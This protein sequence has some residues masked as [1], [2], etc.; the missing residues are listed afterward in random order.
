MTSTIKYDTIV[1]IL[2]DNWIIATFVVVAVIISFIPPLREGV[3]L[4][5]E[6]CKSLF[7]K[8]KKEIVSPQYTPCS[9]WTIAEGDRVRHI[10]E[11][12][13]QRYGILTVVNIK[14]DYVFCYVG[15]PFNQNI[16]TFMINELTVE[17]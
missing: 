6:W 1:N 2:L 13:F 4:I 16:Q 15:N 3:K 14:G 17:K 8:K 11:A 10:D 12:L 9:S 5:V 7:C